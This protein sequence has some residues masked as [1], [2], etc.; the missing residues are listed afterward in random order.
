MKLEG[1]LVSKIR[2]FFKDKPVLKAY[3]FGSFR[4]GEADE[5]SDI[6]ILVELDYSQPIGIEFVRMKLELEDIL[7]RK[8]DLL[9]ERAVSKY[10]KH[11]IENE[12]LLIYE[13]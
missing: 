2:D 11:Y 9:S 5:N 1:Y 7:K 13:K 4:R 8:V 10:V 3:L 6:D 12:K